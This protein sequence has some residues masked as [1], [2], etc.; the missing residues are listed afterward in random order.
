MNTFY[1]REI[2]H[3]R[4]GDKGDTSNVGVIAYRPEYYPIMVRQVT[5]HR[6]K[7]HFA[8]LVRGEVTRYELPLVEALNFVLEQALGGGVTRSLS[9]DPHGKSYSALMLTLT[10]EVD[11]A[12]TDALLRAGR[13]PVD[14]SAYACDSR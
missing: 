4:A 6:V 2:A 14:D 13:H 11:E 7:A 3:A 9:L 8:S 1:L 12:I 5:P 10:V